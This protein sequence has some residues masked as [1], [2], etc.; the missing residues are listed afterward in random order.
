MV[1]RCVSSP[2]F[3]PTR[4]RIRN[5]A[6]EEYQENL[7]GAVLKDGLHFLALCGAILKFA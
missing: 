6:H 4:E 7:V 3:R 5:A 1:G 2:Q